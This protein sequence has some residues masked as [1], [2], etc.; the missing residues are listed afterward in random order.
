[1]AFPEHIRFIPILWPTLQ[2]CPCM[3]Y[4]PHNNTRNS[5]RSLHPICQIKDLKIFLR[6]WLKMSLNLILLIDLIS[7]NYGIVYTANVAMTKHTPGTL[8]ILVN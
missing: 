8:F 1:M 3:P 4:W 7:E 2:Q 6:N 5:W